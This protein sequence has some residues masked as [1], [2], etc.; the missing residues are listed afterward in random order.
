MTHSDLCFL[1]QLLDLFATKT[2]N[3]AFSDLW[4]WREIKQPHMSQPYSPVLFLTS[5]LGC[6]SPSDDW[7]SFKLQ[8]AAFGDAFAQHG[9]DQSLI[10]LLIYQYLWNM[11][12]ILLCVYTSIQSLYLPTCFPQEFVP[13]SGEKV[14]PSS[15]LSC[16]QLKILFL[17][18]SNAKCKNK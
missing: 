5:F 9:A 11:H 8:T 13:S 12:Q 7:S 4:C 18:V 17:E 15:K 1:E 10:Y 14:A 6:D 3:F 16:S 2:I